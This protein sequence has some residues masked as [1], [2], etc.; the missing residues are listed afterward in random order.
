MR[1]EIQNS[2]ELANQSVPRT[3]Q[4]TPKPRH[5]R[6][7]GRARADTL[8][9]RMFPTRGDRCAHRP[10]DY[11]IGNQGGPSRPPPFRWVRSCSRPGPADSRMLPW[12]H[13]TTCRHWREFND[14]V[15]A[16][17]HSR[18]FKP[19]RRW[20]WKVLSAAR[21]LFS[22]LWRSPRDHHRYAD[23]CSD[24]RGHVRRHRP[25]SYRPG[26]DREGDHANGR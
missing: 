22:R 25:A 6:G 23:R 9:E 16:G 20:V 1:L 15:F 11:G 18:Q 21:I 5:C 10:L 26:A 8:P 17:H 24:L 12:T 19:R 2:E 13:G 14:E 3:I 4:P 7:V